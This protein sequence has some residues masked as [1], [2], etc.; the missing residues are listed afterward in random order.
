MLRPCSG[1]SCS[2]LNPDQNARPSPRRCRR[3]HGGR[4]PH[5]LP[6]LDPTSATRP[7]ACT[8]RRRTFSRHL[9]FGCEACSRN[10]GA[11]ALLCCVRVHAPVHALVHASVHAPM[12]AQ[13]EPH[14]Q[15]EQELQHT[16]WRAR[17]TTTTHHFAEMRG[18][19]EWGC[20]G[21]LCAGALLSTWCV[22]TISY[23]CCVRAQWTR[24]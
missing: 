5:P 17:R 19:L 4:P 23:V 14:E 8:A 24:T 20:G 15:G 3:R 21:G 18:V 12:H 16:M 22:C 13:P 1:C 6:G 10:S 11:W 7:L 2:G 9:T